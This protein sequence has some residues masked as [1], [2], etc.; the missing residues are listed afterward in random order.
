MA[1]DKLVA[2]LLR[3]PLFAGLKPLQLTEIARQ[4]ERVKFRPGDVITKAG[5][6]GDGAYL[7]VSGPAEHVEPPDLEA[8][9]GPVEPGSLIGEMAMLVEHAYRATVVARDRVFCLKIMR[10]AVHA[11]MLEDAALAGISSAASPSGC[12]GWQRSCDGSTAFSPRA[13]RTRHNRSRRPRNRSLCLSSPPPRPTL[14]AKEKRPT[15]GEELGARSAS[16]AGAGREAGT[17]GDVFRL[18]G[19]HYR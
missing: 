6:P 12:R 4:A 10:A 17:A 7:I 1:I 3:V 11:Q 2:P 9:A 14:R 16:C 15:P 13:D 8:A 19:G 18:D 5:E